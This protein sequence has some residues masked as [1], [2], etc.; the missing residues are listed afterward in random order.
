MDTPIID[1]FLALMFFLIYGTMLTV[2]LWCMIV[3]TILIV[4]GAIGYRLES[5]SRKR[6][7]YIVKE[8]EDAAEE[9]PKSKERKSK[10]SVG[11]DEDH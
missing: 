6:H 7:L 2:N 4:D 10:E 8:I 9:L 5:E 3:M 11:S 1:V